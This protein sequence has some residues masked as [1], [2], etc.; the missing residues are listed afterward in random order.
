MEAHTSLP[1]SEY[2]ERMRYKVRKIIEEDISKTSS[3]DYAY[4][5][6]EKKIVDMFFLY[7]SWSFDV[8]IAYD[9]SYGVH[10]SIPSRSDMQSKKWKWKKYH[11]CKKIIQ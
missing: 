10:K 1:D 4:E 8:F 2:I 6:V 9:E 3:S 7:V 5:D 11:L